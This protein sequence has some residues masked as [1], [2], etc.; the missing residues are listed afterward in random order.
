MI[1][2]KPVLIDLSDRSE[3]GYGGAVCGTGS[4]QTEHCEAGPTAGFCCDGN[5]ATAVCAVNKYDD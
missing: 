3:K 5:T 1:Y 4:G 2:E